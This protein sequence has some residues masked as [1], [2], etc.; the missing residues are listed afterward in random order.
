MTKYSF[1]VLLI[2]HILCDFYFQSPNLAKNKKE[3]MYWVLVHV[4]IYTVSAIIILMFLMPG[5]KWSYCFGFALGHAIIDVGKYIICNSKYTKDISFFKKEQNIFILDQILHLFVIF[6]LVYL[7]KDFRVDTIFNRQLKE[8]FDSLEISET[9]ALSWSIKLLLIH[10]PTN[11]FISN[12]LS[13]Y[14]PDKK[15][16]PN[17]SDKNAGRF[18]GT[19]ERIIM[20][21]LM[22]IHQYSAVGLVLTAKSIARYDKISK[23]QE[24]AEYYLLGTLLST[25]CAIGAS[26]VF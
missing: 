3:K 12:V 24:F 15:E 22:S 18:I 13:Q 2:A 23:D 17:L 25:L 14:R 5:L 7:I 26:I 16:S 21:L 6:V 9:M 4:T 1:I 8:I 19:L 10:K 20:V 11:I